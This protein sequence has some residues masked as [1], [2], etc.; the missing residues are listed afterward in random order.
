MRELRY[1]AGG[2]GQIHE[3]GGIA[4]GQC[5]GLAAGWLMPAEGSA[6]Y[7][8]L[9]PAGRRRLAADRDRGPC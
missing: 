6:G 3:G 9:T 7:L 4:R 5:A 8:D 2:V 1:C